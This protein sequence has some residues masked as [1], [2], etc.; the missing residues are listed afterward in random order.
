MPHFIQV[1][2]LQKVHIM[3]FALCVMIVALKEEVKEACIVV[4]DLTKLSTFCV[5]F[6]RF[7]RGMYNRYENGV[8]PREP[9]MDILSAMK[10]HSSSLDDHVQYLESVSIFLS[11]QSG[12]VSKVI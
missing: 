9:I 1:H 3:I 10:D 8:H 11:G 4:I 7:W 12:K 6:C 2:H 5:I